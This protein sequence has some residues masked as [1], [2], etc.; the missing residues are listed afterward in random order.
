MRDR[1]ARGAFV[2]FAF[3][4]TL[5]VPVAAHAERVERAHIA[6]LRAS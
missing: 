6:R 3:L 2:A 1:I 4:V 5:L